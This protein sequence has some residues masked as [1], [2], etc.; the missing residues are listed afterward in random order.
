MTKEALAELLMRVSTW[1][2]EAKEELAQSIVEIE[3]RHA[4]EDDLSDEDRAALERGLA[5]ADAGR[6]APDGAV[7]ALFD[8]Y[9][10]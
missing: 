8:R 2:E 1:S 4:D 5:D 7:Q 10:K 3:A 6:F 9:F